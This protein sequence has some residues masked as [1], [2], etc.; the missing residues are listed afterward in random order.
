MIG[1]LTGADKTAQI[2]FELARKISGR[3]DQRGNS[4]GLIMPLVSKLRNVFA[5]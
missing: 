4:A 3:M 1:E 2:F 5:S